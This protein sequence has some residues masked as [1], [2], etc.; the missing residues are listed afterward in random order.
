MTTPATCDWTSLVDVLLQDNA[1]FDLHSY[2][3]YVCFFSGGKDSLCLPLYLLDAGVHPSKIEL[4]HHLVDGEGDNFMDWNC[5]KG[6]C[7]AFADHFGMKL[8]HSFREGGFLRELRRTNSRTAPVTFDSE[9][10]DRRTMGG[11]RGELSTRNLFP[12]V[13]ADLR[14]RWCSSNLKID[15][16]R[17][18]LCNEPRFRNSRTLVLTGERAE[19]SSSRA[20]YAKFEPHHSDLRSSPKLARHIDT[21]RAVHDWP[22]QKVWDL[23]RKYRIR[24]HPAYQMG[25]SRVSCRNCVFLGPN[26][27][28]TIKFYFRPSFDK[29]ADEERSTGKTIHRTKTLDQ[30]ADVGVPFHATDELAAIANSTVYNQ[31]I[32]MNDWLLPPGAFKRGCGPQ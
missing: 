4:H 23:I 10:G 2:E 30:L 18:I 12:Q 31:S 21:L 11:D 22:E 26:E 29:V 6:Y 20:K 9:T 7:Q 19:E 25:F 17:R 13:S 27:L 3:R 5:T 14:V 28:A 8:F 32:I 16:G 1:P 24:P 15:V